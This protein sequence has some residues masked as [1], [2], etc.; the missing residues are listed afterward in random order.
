LKPGGTAIIGTPNKHDPFLRPLLVWGLE[1]F[2]KYPYS[3]ELCFSRREL[4]KI[5]EDGGFEFRDY[6]GILFFPGIL[7][8]LDVFLYKH[9][10]PLSIVTKLALKPFEFLERNFAFFRRRGYLIACVAIKR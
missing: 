1:L 2:D 8:I 7:R 4:R 5:L 9:F 6:T 10:M 3:P